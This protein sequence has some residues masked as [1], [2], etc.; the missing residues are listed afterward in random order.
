MKIQSQVMS[1]EGITYLAGPYRGNINHNTYIAHKA[2]MWLWSQ[3]FVVFCPH[4]NSGGMEVKVEESKLM[5]GA[6]RILLKCDRMAVL[7]G[8]RE[9]VGT[10][11]EM[12][13]AREHGISIHYIQEVQ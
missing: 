2:A 6:I 1:K 7:P 8:W 3:G 10:L 13:V 12:Q 9:S 11:A 4:L 5:E